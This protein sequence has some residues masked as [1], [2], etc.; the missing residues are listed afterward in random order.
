MIQTLNKPS[1]IIYG[2]E[3]EREQALNNYLTDDID[4][5]QALNNYLGLEIEREQGLN[6]YLGNDK[7]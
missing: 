1:S 6:N 2:L 3:I 4:L 5:K 7:T